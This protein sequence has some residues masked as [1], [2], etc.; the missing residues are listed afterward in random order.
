MI[1]KLKNRV[2]EFN[3]ALPFMDGRE[4][5]ELNS[6]KNV[7]VTIIDY[8]FMGDG[9]DE[10]IAFITKEVDDLFYFGG[11]V[12][13]EQIKELDSEG[14]GDTIREEG[15]PVLFSD[16]KSKNNRV[17]THVTYFPEEE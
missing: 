5:G 17:Y 9:D 4:K 13:T 10:Y 6:I 14:Y 2:K 12:L 1:N 11:K 7:P 16:R 3:N 8:G 15:L